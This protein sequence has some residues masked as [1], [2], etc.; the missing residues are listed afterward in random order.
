MNQE[1]EFD[2]LEALCQDILL[3]SKDLDQW[4]DRQIRWFT[5]AM[6]EL[7][8]IQ[9]RCGQLSYWVEHTSV[10]PGQLL[11]NADTRNQP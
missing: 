10:R 4:Q 5:D 3:L 2:T 8:G 7:D 11:E 6:A 9:I 1:E